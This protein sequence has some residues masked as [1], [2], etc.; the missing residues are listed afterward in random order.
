MEAKLNLEPREGAGKGAARKLRRAGRVPGVVYGGDGDAVMVSM[1][2]RE[3][4]NL[5]HHISVENTILE[6]DMGGDSTTQALVRE[7]QAHPHRHELIH[8][9]FMRITAGVAMEVSVPLHLIGTPEGVRSE[10]GTLEHIIHDV[11]VKCLPSN[12]PEVIELDVTHLEIGDALRAKD[13]TLPPDVENLLDP[14][15]T[16]CLVAAPRAEEEEAVDE[17]ALEGEVPEGDEAVGTEAAAEAGS[18]AT[19]TGDSDD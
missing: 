18:D 16:I 6:L 12:I 9:D 10:G 19:D 3:A 15:R 11:P 13:L 5:F 17:E 1:E 8:V 14:E 4:I 7:I 2:S